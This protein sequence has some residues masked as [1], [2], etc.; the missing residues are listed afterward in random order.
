MQIS[1]LV[2]VVIPYIII[3][4][5]FTIGW[6]RNII[7]ATGIITENPF[8]SILIPVKNEEAYVADLIRS[9][10]NQSYPKHKFEVLFI[11]DHSRDNTVSEIEKFVESHGFIKLLKLR[12]DFTGKKKALLTGFESA[13]G[14]YIITTDGDCRFNPGWILAMARY[15]VNYPHHLLI[16]PVLFRQENGM[17]HQFQNLE[18]LSLIASG[19]GAVGIGHPILCNGANLGAPR[20]VFLSS[21]NVYQSA[22]LSGDDIFLL[23]EVKRRKIPVVFVKDKEAVVITES[24]KNIR[25]FINQRTRWTYKSRYY[26]D[27][28]ILVVAI[29]VLLT[30]LC[31]VTGLI[32][33]IFHP[34]FLDDFLIFYLLKS[35]ADYVLLYYVARFFNQKQLL[36]FFL[37]HQL[38]YMFYVSFV[39]IAGHFTGKQWKQTK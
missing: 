29:V 17:L 3:I 6:F 12:D 32:Y 21:G 10:I 18:F 28:D 13:Q 35:I 19:A 14:E 38:L 24:T 4:I 7:P 1:L 22:I 37:V 16:G 39:G 9:L 5:S 15:F 36:R 2:L 26:K 27:P 25:G 34:Q 8:V 23:L 33:A 31:M 30:G 20:S 11:D